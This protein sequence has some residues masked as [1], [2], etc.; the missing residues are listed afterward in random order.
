MGT[1]IDQPERCEAGNIVEW[2]D[3]LH[4]AMDKRIPEIR[5]RLNCST[6]EAIDLLRLSVEQEWHSYR[7]NDLNVKDEQLA[8]LGDLLQ[9]YLKHLGVD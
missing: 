2:Y 8:G 6:G 9:R 7:V 4:N 5:E 1:L 3:Y